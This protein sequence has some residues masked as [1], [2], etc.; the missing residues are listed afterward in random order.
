[1]TADEAVRDHS[2]LVWTEANR[3]FH[4]GIGR[5]LGS[6]EDCVQVGFLGLL[7]AARL[8]DTSKGKFSTYATPSIRN[9]IRAAAMKCLMVYVSEHTQR[10][11]WETP[12]GCVRQT[13][14]RRAIKTGIV[15]GYAL[16]TH[17]D[18]E[19][20]DGEFADWDRVQEAIRYHFDKKR[21]RL[22][23]A[24]Y[25]EGLDYTA[26]GAEFGCSRQWVKDLHDRCI[27]K[28]RKI[29]SGEPGTT[30]PVTPIPG[31]RET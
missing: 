17:L 13:D 10:Q 30:R 28:L 27:R 2:G 31:R 24:R 19:H 14:A 22:F 1:M 12:N 23:Q 4:Q 5:R 15:P 16:N 26:I 25:F 9:A 29:L 6:V 20:W 7:N 8:Y 3:S 21:Q 11:L 18:R